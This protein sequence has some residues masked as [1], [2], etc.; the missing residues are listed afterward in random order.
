MRVI[1]AFPQF[2]L[3]FFSSVPVVIGSFIYNIVIHCFIR[4]WGGGLCVVVMVVGGFMV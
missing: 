4:G 3:F 2:L 1:I